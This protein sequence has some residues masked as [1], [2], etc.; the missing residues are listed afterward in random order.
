[1]PIKVRPPS[2][3]ELPDE[4]G[5]EEDW[6]AE[7]SS[8]A[9][10]TVSDSDSDCSQ[11]S[12]T[13]LW[14]PLMGAAGLHRSGGRGKGRRVST[15]AVL[16]LCLACVW[17]ASHWASVR[18]TLSI[19]RHQA[20][21][22]ASVGTA[23]SAAGHDVAAAGTKTALLPLPGA[24][25]LE[26]DVCNGFANQRIALLSGARLGSPAWRAGV[27]AA[28]ELARLAAAAAEQCSCSAQHANSCR[29]AAPHAEQPHTL[30]HPTCRPG[31]GLGAQPLSSAAQPHHGWVHGGRAQ[32]CEPAGRRDRAVWVRLYAAAPAVVLVRVWMAPADCGA[33]GSRKRPLHCPTRPLPSR[34]HPQGLVRPRGVC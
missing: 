20:A 28:A 29:A 22:V 18:G 16:L 6:A 3:R 19:H 26:F 32:V 27:L 10:S 17:G 13:A 24:R 2:C 25:T 33:A 12:P 34:S 11:D 8:D 14:A 23:A 15:P 7:D 4:E 31:A 1:M 30:D 21:T 9:A 5:W